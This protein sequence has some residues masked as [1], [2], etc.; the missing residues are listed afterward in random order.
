MVKYTIHLSACCSDIPNLEPCPKWTALQEV[1]EEIG[2]H[3]SKADKKFG[4]GR[5]LIAAE[6]DRTCAQIREVNAFSSL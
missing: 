4:P 6:D 2:E 1:M 3:N 5:V